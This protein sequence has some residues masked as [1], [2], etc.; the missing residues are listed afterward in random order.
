METILQT[1]N[2][3]RTSLTEFWGSLNT[4]KKSLLIGTTITLFALVVALFAQQSAPE[5]AYLYQDLPQSDISQIAEELQKMNVPDYMI[6]DK[7]IKVPPDQV[8]PLRLRL[9]EEG[10]PSHGQIGWEKFDQQDF[11]R[12][13]FEQRIHKIRAIQGE[14]GRTI[15]GIDG[16]QSAR[17]HITLP[18]KS[19]FVEDQKDPTAAVYVKAK[20]GFRLSEKQINGIVHLVSRSVEGM[21][22]EKVAIIDKDGK[23]LT[24]PEIDD[25]TAKQTREMLSYR[26][27]LENE[28]KTR[29]IELLSR[30]VGPE[31]VE[32]K[33]D[34]LVDFT[35]EEQTINDIDPDRVVVLSSNT[36]SQEMDGNGLNPTGIPGSKSNVPGEQQELTVNSTRAKSKRDTERL[37]Y[38]IAKTNRRRLLPVG[39]IKRISA[40]VIVDGLQPYPTDGT[41]PEFQPR[42]EEEMKKIDEIVKSAIGFKEGR[43]TVQVKNILF[44]LAPYQLAAIKEKKEE[45]RNYI[46]TLAISSTIALALVLF[47]ALI[48]RPYFRWLSYDPERKAREANVDEFKP[49]LE[50]GG[51]QNVQVKEDVPFEKLSPQEQIL[52]LAKNEPERT[53]EAIRMLLN[54]HHNVG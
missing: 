26:R 31:R 41:K 18:K 35:Q 13:E 43:D 25:P 46:A 10:L 7:G 22:P 47:F 42:S 21:N 1:I 54:P 39:N 45:S 28:Y 3:W 49:D 36:S 32:A 14:L 51:I 16:I 5:Y 44:E 24:K 52:F 6:D 15:S 20:R 17:V 8:M 50:L 48:V 9:A 27:S 37:N 23:M 30:I 19:L 2:K 33:V 53:T 4:L 29:I 40:A 11:T 12:T 38:E 34:V